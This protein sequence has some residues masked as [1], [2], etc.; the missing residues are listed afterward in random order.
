[1]TQVLAGEADVALAVGAEKM[2]VRDPDRTMAVFDTAYDVSDP[3]RARP[4]AQGY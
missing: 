2:H 1:M 3:S 4:H